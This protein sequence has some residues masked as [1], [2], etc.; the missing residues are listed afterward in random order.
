MIVSYA[1]LLYFF[2]LP[3]DL[4]F[5]PALAWF[6][7]GLI[8]IGT[9]LLPATSSLIMVKLGRISSMEMDQ[10]RERNWPL[11]QAAVIYATCA[12]ALNMRA[13]PEFIELFLIGATISMVVALLIN[14]K[15]KISLHMIGAGGLCGGIAGELIFGQMGGGAGILATCFFLTGALGSARLFLD[16][17]TPMQVLAGFLAGFAI[18]LAMMGFFL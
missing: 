4:Q 12:Y 11:L 2:V 8:V 3:S 18:E 14:L 10:Q 6:V 13:V 9:V 1:C 7:T 16:S 17:H 5:P 15:W